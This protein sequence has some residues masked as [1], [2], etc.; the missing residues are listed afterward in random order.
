LLADDPE[1][2]R[3]FFAWIRE[4]SADRLRAELEA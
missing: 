3:I 4:R 1:I 2:E